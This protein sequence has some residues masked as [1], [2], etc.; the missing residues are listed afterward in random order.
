MFQLKRYYVLFIIVIVPMVFIGCG[1]FLCSNSDDDSMSTTLRVELPCDAE[2][3]YD[4]DCVTYT[5]NVEDEVIVSGEEGTVY[6]VTIRVRGV[7][8]QKT[9]Y[10]T[11]LVTREVYDEAP[12][13]MWLDDGL[14]YSH[15]TWNIFSIEVTSP[16]AIYYLNN[17]SSGTLHCWKFDFEK[18]ILA[19]AGATITLYADSGGLDGDEIRII[20]NQDSEYG[21]PL[22]IP[23]I[24][25]APDAFDGQFVQMDIVSMTEATE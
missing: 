13:F 5:E 2:S 3:I 12:D 18:T 21:D 9:Y 6:N 20:L 10:D 15:D 14:K 25:P 19:D 16:P 22:I 7:V 11:P 4:H 23:G 24:P 1:D 8:E 17:G